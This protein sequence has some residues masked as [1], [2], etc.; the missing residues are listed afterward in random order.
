MAGSD[1]LFG[2]RPSTLY[3]LYLRRGFAS[4]EDEVQIGDGFFFYG[5]PTL[6]MRRGSNRAQV[7]LGGFLVSFHPMR[8]SLSF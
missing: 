5:D 7:F 3:T 8:V 2:Y 4:P 1:R 6:F